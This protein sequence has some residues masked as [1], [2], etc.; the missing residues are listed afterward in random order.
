MKDE[1]NNLLEVTCSRLPFG[2]Y[3]S[4]PQNVGMGK[5]VSALVSSHTLPAKWHN[6]SL[7]KGGCERVAVYNSAK[8]VL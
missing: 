3:L 8:I 1:R 5:Q 6:L 4:L 2:V 7:S